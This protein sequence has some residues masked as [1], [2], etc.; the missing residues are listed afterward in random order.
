MP[1]R[2]KRIGY[3]NPLLLPEGYT[4]QQPHQLLFAHVESSPTG[5]LRVAAPN[6]SVTRLQL[7][8]NVRECQVEAVLTACRDEPSDY[9]GQK[10][11]P[12]SIA[13]V[14]HVLLRRTT[15]VI[16]RVD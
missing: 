13:A 11:D 16:P 4:E 3:E 2:L 1:S 5:F 8:P 12:A 15:A 9:S 14:Q 6:S 10:K 7:F